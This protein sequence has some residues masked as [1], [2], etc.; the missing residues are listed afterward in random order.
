MQINN[1]SILHKNDDNDSVDEDED[2][3]DV[4]DQNIVRLYRSR[5]IKSI[6]RISLKVFRCLRKTFPL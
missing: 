2:V 1:S 4:N 6:P 5:F 3:D